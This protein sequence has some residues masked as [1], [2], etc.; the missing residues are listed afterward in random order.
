LQAYNLMY[1]ARPFS[2]E[3]VFFKSINK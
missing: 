2:N 3:G 1:T